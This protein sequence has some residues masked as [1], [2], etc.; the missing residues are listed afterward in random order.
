MLTRYVQIIKLNAHYST[1]TVWLALSHR[2]YKARTFFHLI[3][4]PLS[5]SSSSL[6]CSLATG[7]LPRGSNIRWWW[8]SIDAMMK[9]AYTTQLRPQDRLGYRDNM[10]LSPSIHSGTKPNS[11]RNVDRSNLPSF[12]NRAGLRERRER[13]QRPKSGFQNQ[14][15]GEEEEDLRRIRGWE[16]FAKGLG[17]H[18][19]CRWGWGTVQTCSFFLVKDIL[20]WTCRKNNRV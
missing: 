3:L 5:S 14:K 12:P 4:L 16:N 18:R 2:P 8:W 17:D 1:I 9:E 7:S 11:W 19:W 20:I 10:A 15:R 13:G 6:F